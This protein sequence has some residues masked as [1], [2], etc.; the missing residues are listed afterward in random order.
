MLRDANA[1]LLLEDGTV[2]EGRGGR[3]RHALRR[4]GV[5]HLDDR[6]PGGADRPLLPR[7][8]RGHDPAAH[9]QLRHGRREP[10]S[11]AGPGSRGSSP[12]ASP[13]GRRATSSEGDLPGLPAAPRRAGARRHRHPRRWCGACASAAR[14]AAC[15]PPS[16]RDVAA[17]AAEVRDFPAMT[18]RA[19]VDEVTCAEPRTS[20]PAD[21]APSA[22]TSRSTTSASRANILRSLADARRAPARCCRRGR[23]PRRCLALGVDGV[24]LSNGPG[25]PEPLTDDHRERCA[26]L[27]DAGVPVFGIC[28]GHQLLGLAL[29]GAHLQAQVRPPRRQPA[30]ARPARPARWRSPARTT[31]SRST[32]TRCP[33]AAA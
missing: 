15:S 28:L 23:R 3:S 21:R 30:G 16:A 27:V 22:A 14:C 24:V 7:P 32:P 1:L 26:T 12:A 5:Q 17:L 9:R 11:P 10:P 18:G 20:S 19:L 13:R 29:G 31:A 2:F 33:P 6:L 4:G 25:D 8:D